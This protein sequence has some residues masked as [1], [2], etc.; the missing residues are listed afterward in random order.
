MF[1]SFKSLTKPPFI[2]SKSKMERSGQCVKYLF[3]KLKIKTPEWRQWLR[4]DVCIVNFSQISE[5]ANVTQGHKSW[6]QFRAFLVCSLYIFVSLIQ[7]IVVTLCL[8][9]LAK[10]KPAPPEILSFP[11][12]ICYLFFYHSDKFSHLSLVSCT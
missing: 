4:S 10:K 8:H 5:Q 11:I 12:R 3:S 9:F 1:L 6:N 2:C 7:V